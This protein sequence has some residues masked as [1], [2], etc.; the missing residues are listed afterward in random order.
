MSDFITHKISVALCT[1]NGA[2]F[3]PAQLASIAQQTRPPDEIIIS[4]DA[5]TDNSV[6]LAKKFA[7]ENKIP[8][9]IL[10]NSQNLGSNKNFEQAIKHCTGEI[11]FLSDQDDF[12]LP[13]KIATMHG[14]FLQQPE[15]GLIFSDADLVDA[16][17]QPLGRRLW[18]YTFPAK[19]RKQ[20]TSEN[21]FTFLLNLSVVTGA[22]TAFRACYRQ[23]FLP[24]P[25]A[26]FY[27]HDAWLA[28]LMS[29][30]TVI[31]SLPVS[32]V[33]YRQHTQQQIGAPSDKFSNRNNYR[34]TSE[35]IRQELAS[36]PELENFLLTTLSALC[37]GATARISPA[38]VSAEIM[39]RKHYLQDLQAHYEA[40]QALPVAK[41]ARLRAVL[42][43]LATRRYARHSRGLLSAAKDFW[44]K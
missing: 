33:K 37:E 35:R 3:L 14:I 25:S 4:D 8:T 24:I 12:W 19:A 16:N 10:V 5:S 40:R 27:V 22:T 20:F 32:L 41:S 39:R 38:Q 21:A 17:L 44:E 13:Q 42:K 2:E 9:R 23:L 30:Q 43:E 6:K 11:I 36:L 29:T 18:D 31:H 28:L 15:I 1:Y 26:G 34:A 7:A